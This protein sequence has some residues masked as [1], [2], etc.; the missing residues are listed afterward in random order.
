[1]KQPAE[2]NLNEKLLEESQEIGRE[3]QERA[4]PETVAQCMTQAQLQLA[5]ARVTDFVPIFF[6]RRAR[7]LL[8]EATEHPTG[9]APTA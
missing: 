3:F 9:P 1:M 7:R 5:D 4:S 6:G 8:R 2:R